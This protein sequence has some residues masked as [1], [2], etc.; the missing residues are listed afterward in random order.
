MIQSDLLA[1]KTSGAAN[2]FST[3]VDSQSPVPIHK[4]GL[5]G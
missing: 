1:L 2:V 3:I 5:D 4:G